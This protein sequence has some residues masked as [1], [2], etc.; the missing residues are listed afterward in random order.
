LSAALSDRVT[1]GWSTDPR[2]DTLRAEK[3]SDE[4]LAAEPGN[5]DA[6]LVKALVYQN[7]NVTRLRTPP[8]PQW[9]AGIAE[10]NAAIAINR[11]LAGAHAIIGYWRLFLGRAAE[12]FSEI[13]TAMK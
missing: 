1:L 10:A 9:E 4:A 7:L 2:A 5:A 11:N 12:G 13:E 8:H 6:H 3:L